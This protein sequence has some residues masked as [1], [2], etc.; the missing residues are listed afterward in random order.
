MAAPALAFRR[1]GEDDEAGEHQFLLVGHRSPL[2]VGLKLA[3]GDA[4]GAK[5]VRAELLEDL[6]GAGPRRVVERQRLGLTG[7][8]VPGGELDDVFGRALGDQQAAALVFDQD[9]NAA[10][11]KI[12]R[13]LVDLGPACI[14]RRAGLDDRGI[15]RIPQSGLEMAVEPG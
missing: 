10:S 3:P 1:I 5:S 9:R 15:E 6:C 13:H 2:A 4:E 14:A 7:L 11:L 8:F 12:E